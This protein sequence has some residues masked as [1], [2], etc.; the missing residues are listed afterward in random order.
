MMIWNE[1]T[2]Q[3][4]VPAFTLYKAS[5]EE[6]VRGAILANVLLILTS[7]EGSNQMWGVFF[8]RS[9]F[10]DKVE[11]K[12]DFILTDGNHLF[13]AVEVKTKWALSADDIVGI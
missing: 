9:S 10:L 6:D 12:P 11:G 7:T 2:P 3:Y 5:E 4:D 1:T 13:L 8:S